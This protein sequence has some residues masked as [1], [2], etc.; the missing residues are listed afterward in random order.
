MRRVINFILA[1][2][3]LI[4][5][6]GCYCWGPGR[7]GYGEHDRG[8]HGEHDRGGGERDRGEHEERR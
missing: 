2:I 8:G 7:G 4:T 5:C 3:L 1:F 6:A